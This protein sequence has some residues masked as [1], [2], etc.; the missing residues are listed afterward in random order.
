MNNIGDYEAHKRDEESGALLDRDA[1]IDKLLMTSSDPRRRV[2]T[3]FVDGPLRGFYA[4]LT[5]REGENDSDLNSDEVIRAWAREHFPRD[6][7]SVYGFNEAQKLISNYEL[8][9]LCRGRIERFQGYSYFHDA[10]P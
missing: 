3:F 6:W 8:K 2:A 5:V 1:R 4:D 9:L 7:A 10:R